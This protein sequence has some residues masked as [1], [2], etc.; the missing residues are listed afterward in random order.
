MTRPATFLLA[1]VAV[2]RVGVAQDDDKVAARDRALAEADRKA[3]AENMAAYEKD[4][5]PFLAAHCNACHSGEK[6]EGDLSLVLL[7]PDMKD[8]ASGAR[9][10][11]VRERLETGE[12]RY[13]VTDEERLRILQGGEQS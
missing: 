6:L 8:S 11:T 1:L 12:G 7:D 2:T 13:R 3:F 9:W 4:V 5:R 10:A